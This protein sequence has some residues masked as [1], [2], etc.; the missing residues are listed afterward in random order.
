[1]KWRSRIP[2][3]NA[4]AEGADETRTGAAALEENEARPKEEK[5]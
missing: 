4:P 1:M 2:R 3:E 5:R